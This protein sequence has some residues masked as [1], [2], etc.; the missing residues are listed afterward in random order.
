[1][2]YINGNMDISDIENERGMQFYYIIR[3]YTVAQKCIP[4]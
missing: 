4:V 2:K 1:M 3:V